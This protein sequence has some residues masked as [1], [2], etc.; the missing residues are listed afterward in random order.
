MRMKGS[1]FNIF[2]KAMYRAKRD[3]NV[4]AWYMIF[5]YKGF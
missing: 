2:L 1:A 4:C 3:G 5:V